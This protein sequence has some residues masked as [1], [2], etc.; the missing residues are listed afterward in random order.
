MAEISG[1]PA[2]SFGGLATGLDTNSIIQKLVALERR[3][4]TNL[5]KD[6][7][8]LETER[9]AW[10]TLR[11]RLE[12]LETAV[13]DMDLSSE[14][15]AFSATSGNT[16]AFTAT[17]SGAA[18]A[19]TWEIDVVS[20][21][22]GESRSTG[23]FAS[24]TD[25]AGTGTIR[26]VSGGSNYDVA[27]ATGASTL[28]GIRD[29]INASDAPVR[30]SIIDDGSTGTPFKLVLTAEET[31]TAAAFTVDLSQF[32]GDIPAFNFDTQLQA[33]ADAHIRVDN[34]DVWRGSN[35]ITD[36]IDGVTLDLS[37]TAVDVSLTVETDLEAVTGKIE[38][39]RDA[40]NDV[41]GFI[42]GHFARNESGVAASRLFGDGGLQRVQRDLRTILA[43]SYS[44]VTSTY[45]SLS[46]IGIRTGSDG[47]MTI[48]DSE[49][50][51]AL[52]ADFDGVTNLFT[53][54]TAGV[55]A[56]L[57]SRFS[58]Y[59]SSVDG[60]ISARTEGLDR[61]VDSVDD[62]IAVLED[63]LETYE[64]SLMKRYATLEQIAGRW[65]AQGGVL[66]QALLG[67]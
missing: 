52:E 46:S 47:R 23:G 44:D 10:S 9:S 40:W 30:A 25:I 36:V 21:A 54:G 67:L 7:R 58:G 32:D 57:K 15:R 43:D 59:L 64:L 49:L 42:D 29:A 37:T 8:G 11:T 3:P 26:I 66:T 60:L 41:V 63:R 19:G 56:A 24:A 27:I 18:T 16:T 34:L 48:D 17:A 45:E 14:F 12:A 5:Q 65:Q 4:I 6:R 20:L 1:L 13:R 53:D 61:R 51:A 62:R 38:A 55:A 35:V 28:E 50:D 2:F 22:R 31:G 39:F 33:A